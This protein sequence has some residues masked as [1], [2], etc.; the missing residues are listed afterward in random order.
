MSRSRPEASRLGVFLDRDGVINQYR[1]DYVRTRAD[2]AYYDFTP[3]AFHLLGQIGL[4]IVVVTNQSGLGR[5]YTT[6]EEVEFLNTQLC[7]DAERW[8]API[9]A[10]EY[11]PHTPQ[12]AC[13]CRKPAPG[14]FERAARRL[15]LRLAGSYLVG[16]APSDVMVGKALGMVTLRVLTGRGSEP[17]SP[18]A[19]PDWVVD[20]LL[21]AV[22]KIAQLEGLFEP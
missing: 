1:P 12:E 14:L 19:E 4:P 9:A 8:G 6:L 11:C 13:R 10:L 5:G 16:D 2:Y 21:A 7:E 15:G 18:Q 3:R 17:A 22:R 20:D